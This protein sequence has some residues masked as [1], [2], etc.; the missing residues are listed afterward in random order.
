TRDG[1]TPLHLASLTGNV[2]LLRALLNESVEA[3]NAYGETPLHYACISRS[4]TIIR[5]LC[6]E[7]SNVNSKS[8]MG[9][10]PIHFAV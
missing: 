3:R 10:T 2:P 9:A 5:V 6:E 1:V 8:D 4:T 7:G